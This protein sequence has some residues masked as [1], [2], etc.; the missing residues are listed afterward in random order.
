VE[1][2]GTCTEINLEQFSMAA[3]SSA[4]HIDDTGISKAFSLRASDRDAFG[5]LAPTK[6]NT[7]AVSVVFKD[8]YSRF[9]HLHYGVY[10][11]KY[12]NRLNVYFCM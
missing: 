10:D 11:Q 3:A 6:G 2:T 4:A 9:L 8:C 7:T 5:P 12:R 1:A